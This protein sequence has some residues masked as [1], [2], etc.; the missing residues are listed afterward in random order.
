[1]SK[2][3]VGF[4]TYRQR[5]IMQTRENVKNSG[6]DLTHECRLRSSVDDMKNNT[7]RVVVKKLRPAA[8]YTANA[9]R[10]AFIP[11]RTAFRRSAA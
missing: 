8:K 7:A 11:K 3:K 1:M 4:L 5:R 9:T 6:S 2:G 10:L